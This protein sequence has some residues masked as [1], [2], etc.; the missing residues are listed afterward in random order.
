M[1]T[2]D[3]FYVLINNDQLDEAEYLLKTYFAELTILDFHHMC[4]AL[5]K[6]Y[7]DKRQL[8]E[9]YIDKTIDICELDMQILYSNKFPYAKTLRLPCLDRL[10]EI[11]KRRDKNHAISL[12]NWAI[13][14]EYV[15]NDYVL[16][17]NTLLGHKTSA[18]PDYEEEVYD[19]SGFNQFEKKFFAYI[20]EQ[21]KENGITIS[22][23]PIITNNNVYLLFDG[24]H[25]FGCYIRGNGLRGFKK[26]KADFIYIL[27]T[28]KTIQY[29]KS[30]PPN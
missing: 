11:Y 8:S 23:E 25:K 1:N 26:N 30:F 4:N 28:L 21:L 3:K 24:I 6:A 12:L 19:E 22:F 18:D 20:E 17:L 7:Y 5:Q 10:I 14:N 15:G 2:K 29:M 27:D 9:Y 13:E 16:I